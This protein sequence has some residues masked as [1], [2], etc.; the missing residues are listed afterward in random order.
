[1]L[2]VAPLYALVAVMITIGV[3]H[4]VAEGFFVQIVPPQLPAPLF[5]VQLSG[6]IEI[7]LG[8]LLLPERT[9]RLAGYALILL[10]IA[11]FPANVYMAV[12]NVQLQNMPE[13]FVQPSPLLLWL[14][15]PLQFVFI[16][17]ALAVAKTGAPLGS[18]SST[19]SS[20]NS[21]TNAS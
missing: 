19:K 4:F 17:W 12:D 6:V 15:L 3:L 13:W 7:A 1:M 11:V 2:R 10:F 20:T 18:S 21:S 14:R 5:L 8:L 9:R 16:Y